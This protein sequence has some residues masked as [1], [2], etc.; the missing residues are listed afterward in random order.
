MRRW[1]TALLTLLVAAQ[2]CWAGMALCCVG[3]VAS[4]GTPGTPGTPGA[5][6]TPGKAPAVLVTEQAHAARAADGHPVCETAG[7]C[8]CHHAGVATGAAPLAADPT[9]P[10]APV[11]RVAPRLKS[12]I[13]ASLDRP[14]WL[15]A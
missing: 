2:L 7:H 4:P 14:N 9:L 10:P 6:G 8:H 3:E 15:R 12:H 5:P 13:P 1:F 11:A